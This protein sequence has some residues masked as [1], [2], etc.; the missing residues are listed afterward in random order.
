MKS[1]D[2][3][4][5]QED[6]QVA[7]HAP[8][9]PQAQEGRPPRDGGKVGDDHFAGPDQPGMT[10]RQDRNKASG[11]VGRHQSNHGRRGR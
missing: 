3:Q 7:Q 8:Q 11:A 10:P 9:P 6:S 5:P 4:H 2:T 1:K